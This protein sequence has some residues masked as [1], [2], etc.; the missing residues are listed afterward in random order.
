MTNIDDFAKAPGKLKIWRWIGVISIIICVLLLVLLMI[1]PL[2]GNATAWAE[3]MRK[4][5]EGLKNSV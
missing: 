5:Y 4:G 3:G 2:V 1:L